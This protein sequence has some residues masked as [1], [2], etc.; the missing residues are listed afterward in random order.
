MFQQKIREVKPVKEEYGHSYSKAS[1]TLNIW[2]YIYVD[3]YVNHHFDIII[4]L[5]IAEAVNCLSKAVEIYT[6]MVMV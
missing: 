2:H 6:D 5:T 4:I 3:T 1:V